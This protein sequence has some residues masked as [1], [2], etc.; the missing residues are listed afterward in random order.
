[1]VLG[2]VALVNDEWTYR[3]RVCTEYSRNTGTSNICIFL[4]WYFGVHLLSSKV[5]P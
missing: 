3:S 4:L 2:G 5:F 1:M